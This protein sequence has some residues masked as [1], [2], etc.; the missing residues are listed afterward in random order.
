MPASGYFISW[1]D[2][3]AHPDLYAF[4]DIRDA[5]PYCTAHIKDAINIPYRALIEHE[6]LPI[7]RMKA[8]FQV[9]ARSP[10]VQ[11]F[12]FSYFYI[13]FRY[14]RAIQKRGEI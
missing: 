8:F 1:T 11:I 2:V 12:L 7:G 14:R 3:A 6:W 10:T 13:V 4:V 9:R 5:A